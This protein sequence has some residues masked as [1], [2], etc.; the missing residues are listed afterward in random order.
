MLCA[1]II[2]TTWLACMIGSGF[3]LKECNDPPQHF[4]PIAT[5]WDCGYC[6]KDIDPILVLQDLMADKYKVCE[7][8]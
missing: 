8:R 5:L 3:N 1:Q 7:G 6:A 4:R 2:Y